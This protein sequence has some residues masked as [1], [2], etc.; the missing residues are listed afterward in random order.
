[1]DYM[2]QPHGVH[3]ATQEA[4]AGE[5]LESR[6]LK[7]A[8]ETEQEL[9]SKHK[10]ETK[11]DNMK[12]KINYLKAQPRMSNIWLEVFSVSFTETVTKYLTR[13]I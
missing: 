10:N 3:P 5:S 7:P 1:M 11:M 12:E 4:E 8:K 6:S 9:V 13:T 2:S